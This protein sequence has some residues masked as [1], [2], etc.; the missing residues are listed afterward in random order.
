MG[1]ALLVLVLV[2]ITAVSVARRHRTHRSTTV[3]VAA[4]A[5]GVR[6]VLADGRREEVSW[7]EVREVDVFTTRVGPHTASGGAVVLYGDASRGCIVPL[8]RLAESDLMAHLH[9]LPGFDPASLVAALGE[10]R[11]DA[12]GRAAL[13]TPRPLSYTT[14]C[15][16]RPD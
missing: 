16:T 11:P 2:A 4:D 13:V 5:T 1:L 9:R 8:D 6:R 3:E 10:R 14:V 15:W 7:P 12:G